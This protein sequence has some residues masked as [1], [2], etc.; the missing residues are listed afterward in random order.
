M[1]GLLTGADVSS[2]H[3]TYL[4]SLLFF[5]KLHGSK[6]TLIEKKGTPKLQ[7]QALNTIIYPLDGYSRNSLESRIFA[8]PKKIIG[9][10]PGKETGMN[11]IL[12]FLECHSC[13]FKRLH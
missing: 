5:S 12:R 7:Q 1:S 10:K 3:Y 13:A 8:L 2:E 9:R 6:T 4:Q 11:R